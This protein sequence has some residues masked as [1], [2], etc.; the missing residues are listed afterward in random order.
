MPRRKPK[1][2]QMIRERLRKAVTRLWAS[3]RVKLAVHLWAERA[4]LGWQGAGR[5]QSNLVPGRLGAGFG[6]WVRGSHLLGKAASSEILPGCIS[7]IRE[8]FV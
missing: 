7:R 4:A 2:K 6:D 1:S 3:G 5:T 8:A